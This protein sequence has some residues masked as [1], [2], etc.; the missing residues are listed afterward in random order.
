MKLRWG[1]IYM[2]LGDELVS[3]FCA[4]LIKVEIAVAK[5]CIMSSYE[6]L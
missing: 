3:C 2:R 5:F 1:K 6:D 4:E